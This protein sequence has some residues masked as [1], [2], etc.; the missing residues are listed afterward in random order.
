[1]KI[2]KSSTEEENNYFTFEPDEGKIFKNKRSETYMTGI[3]CDTEEDGEK[4][5]QKFEEVKKEG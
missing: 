3:V 2:I 5:L 1:M 4:A